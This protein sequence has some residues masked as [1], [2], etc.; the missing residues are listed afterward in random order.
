MRRKR[1]NSMDEELASVKKSTTQIVS[2][3]KNGS[4]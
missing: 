4:K 2:R 3:R 1:R